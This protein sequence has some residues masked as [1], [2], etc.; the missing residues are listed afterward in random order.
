MWI[1]CAKAQRI[2]I[3]RPEEEEHPAAKT[4]L[5]CLAFFSLR[6]CRRGD[7]CTCL[8]KTQALCT[9]CSDTHPNPFAMVHETRVCFSIP[10]CINSLWRL[11]YWTL[12]FPYSGSPLSSLALQRQGLNLLQSFSVTVSMEEAAGFVGR[13]LPIFMPVTIY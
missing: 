2:W 4:L 1:S 3:S 10:S 11:Y 7:F 6:H 5:H 12:F 13:C 9:K 8:G